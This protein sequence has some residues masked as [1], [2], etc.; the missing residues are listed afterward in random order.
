M[1]E[2]AL[3]VQSLRQP[4]LGLFRK[5]WGQEVLDLFSYQ[6]D[7]YLILD[8]QRCKEWIFTLFPPRWIHPANQAGQIIAEMTLN[9]MLLVITGL[10]L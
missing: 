7:I 5:A 9:V 2:E 6:A 10:L 8:L 3:I 1:V 4:F